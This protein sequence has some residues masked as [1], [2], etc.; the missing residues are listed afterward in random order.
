MDYSV[1]SLPMWQTLQRYNAL[2]SEARTMFWRAASL[3][4]FIRARLRF[5]GYKKTQQ[6]L[7][8]KLDART[9]L[10]TEARDNSSALEMTCRMV[11]AA[12]HYSPG[13]ATCLEESLLLWFLLQ[14][15]NTPA[16]LRIGVRKHSAKFEAHAWVEQN[17]IALNQQDERHH[18]YAAFDSERLNPPAEQ[19]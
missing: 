12:E 14:S 16:V 15:Q 13:Q 6:W 10:P 19:P 11:R 9:K 7:Q 1:C 17:G 18:H 2:P 5:G 8:E 4:P 3:L